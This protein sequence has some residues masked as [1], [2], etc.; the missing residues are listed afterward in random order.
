[1]AAIAAE[2]IVYLVQGNK[3]W[4]LANAGG[5]NHMR[6]GKLANGVETRVKSGTSEYGNQADALVRAQSL[7]KAKLDRGY[8]SISDLQPVSPAKTE[9]TRR[10]TTVAGGGTLLERSALG[11][12]E[13]IRVLVNGRL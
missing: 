12:T 13:Y 6:Y 11:R 5:V 8:A 1:M 7:I 2:G 3:F 10:T 4:E 9:I